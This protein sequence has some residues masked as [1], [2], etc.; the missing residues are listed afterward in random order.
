M[1]DIKTASEIHRQLGITQPFKDW[2]TQQPGFGQFES[3][4]GKLPSGALG[5]T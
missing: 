5:T 3:F 4:Y 2:I 1:T